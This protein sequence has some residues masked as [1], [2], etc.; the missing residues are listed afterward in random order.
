MPWGAPGAAGS[1]PASCPSLAE[2]GALRNGTEE[3]LSLE[4]FPPTKRL[5]TNPINNSKE[6]RMEEDQT[7]GNRELGSSVAWATH[8][9]KHQETSLGKGSALPRGHELGFGREKLLW[10]CVQAHSCL[11][12]HQQSQGQDTVP[13]V[14]RH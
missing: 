1:S 13:R 4:Q 11:S 5:K 12:R 7:R 3:V 6:Q 10:S 9:E 8:P 14:G 2:S